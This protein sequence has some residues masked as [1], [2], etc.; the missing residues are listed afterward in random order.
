MRTYS[1]I[2]PYPIERGI[3][4]GATGKVY[5]GR[6]LKLDRDVAIKVLDSHLMEEGKYKE[7]FFREAKA[8]AALRHPN[9]VDIYDFGEAQKDLLYLVME[10][11]PGPN[12]G[13]FCRQY[14]SF[15]E[16]IL[17]ALGIALASALGKMHD[18]GIIHRDIKPENIFMDSG[19]IVLGD[20]GIAKAYQ[21]DNPLGK[22]AASRHTEVVGT[23]GFMAP[24][25]L[26][27]APLGQHTDIFAWGALLYYLGTQRLPY[28]A[29]SPYDLLEKFRD[30]RPVPLNELRLDVSDELSCLVQSCLETQVEYRP[31]SMLFIREECQKIF[32]QTGA[33]EPRELL[34]AFEMTPTAFRVSDKSRSIA[35]LVQQ[36]KVAIRDQDSKRAEALQARLN[37]L[38]PEQQEAPRLSGLSQILLRQAGILKRLKHA[39]KRQ[40]NKR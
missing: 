22:N 33:S 18:N 38:D 29:Q 17:V 11:I 39:L 6:D 23:P 37:I 27:E 30:S 2:G 12:V 7:R 34:K 36:L 5:L 3:G 13:S 21:P 9:I 10:Y 14:G 40:F 32:A 15:P 35:Y 1:S 31:S 24:E 28:D 8:I 16:S 4:R 25:Q 20:L 26:E 19:R